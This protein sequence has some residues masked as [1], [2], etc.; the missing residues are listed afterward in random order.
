MP[1]NPEHSPI[2]LAIE[3][4]RLEISETTHTIS[5]RLVRIEERQESSRV[6]ADAR[7]TNAM[8]S[9]ER[10]VPRTEIEEMFRTAKE[11]G[12]T[13]QRE[14]R[15]AHKRIDVLERRMWMSVIGTLGALAKVL[16][17]AIGV[18]LR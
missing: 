18:H 11:R 16:F 9:L 15:E 13:C 14:V 17:D 6:A 12:D 4:L 5:E 1:E 8:Q 10:S 2:F 7:H 3:R